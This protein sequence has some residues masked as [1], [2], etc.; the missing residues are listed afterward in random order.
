MLP[1][2]VLLA[3]LLDRFGG[4]AQTFDCFQQAGWTKPLHLSATDFS[5]KD[6]VYA[7]PFT[8]KTRRW[9]SV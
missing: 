1:D 4:M 5:C 3:M 2:S 9:I 6:T 8:L 7:M